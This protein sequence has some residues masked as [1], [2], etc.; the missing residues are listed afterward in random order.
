MELVK[1]TS[2]KESELKKISSSIIEEVTDGNKNPLDVYIQAKALQKISKDVVDS[3]KDQARNEADEYSKIDS[4]L[5]GAKFSISGSAKILNY[6]DDS[7]YKRI[8]RE[9]EERK[10]NLKN[11]YDLSLKD[12]VLIDSITGE[13]IPVVSVKKFSEQIIKVSF[14]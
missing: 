2:Y 9:L 1:I 11:A 8:K 5:N 14:K 12:N 6:E 7:E 3:I 4:T 10:N 13:E